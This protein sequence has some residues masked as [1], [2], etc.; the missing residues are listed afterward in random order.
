MQ[1]HGATW[2]AC[3][4]MEPGRF[5]TISKIN[6]RY[7][8]LILDGVTASNYERVYFSLYIVDVI[9]ETR[10]EDRLKGLQLSQKR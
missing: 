2:E 6:K 7:T 10:K 3:K 5:G 1:Y 4:T 8:L 9:G